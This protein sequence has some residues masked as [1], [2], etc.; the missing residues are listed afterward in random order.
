[1][2]DESGKELQRELQ[3]AREA[4]ATH[5][6]RLRILH[7]I[8][9]AV[10]TEKAP[11]AIA[12]AVVQPLRA[13]LRVPR[14]IVNIFDLAAG[15]AEWLAA[16]GRHRT[17]VGPGVRY[18][19]RLMGDVE[20]LRR[21]EPQIIDVDALPASP[22]RQA[23][24]A[25]GVRIYMAVP[26]IA[27]GELSGAV[28]FGGES[29]HFPVEQMSIAT[30]VATQLAIAIVQARLYERVKQQAAELERRVQERTQDL[31]SANR[32]L[33]AFTYTVSHDLKAP[34]RAIEGF[35]RVLVED[36]AEV[37]DET[38]RRHL[39]RIQTA[40]TRMDRLIE[41]LL[42]YSRIERGAI[43]R[44][45]VP[46]EPIIDALCEE[47]AEE[48]ETRG[49]TVRRD[50]DV[51]QVLAEREGLREAIAN[52]L[53]NAVKFSRNQG[54]PITVSSRRDGD[55]IIITV[56]DHGIGFEMKYHDRIFGMFER[57]H[58]Q[59]AYPGTGVGL[60]IVRKVAERH[61]GRAWAESTLGQ[62]SSFHFALPVALGSGRS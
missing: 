54:E 5:A 7:E 16:A 1:M 13:L 35:A 24:L 31:E 56:A 10:V 18:S 52:L 37:L 14:A 46:L 57:L 23:L 3:S 36:Y 32:E 55:S 15:E 62:G 51:P 49:L 30:E 12:E 27:G 61:G 8:D 25:S 59:E 6:E 44:R 22:E 20:A 41:D 21:G 17:H 47:L 40:A 60:A 28:S 45:P 48:I 53:S 39:A 34:L 19:L 11:A 58:S 4:L 33:E 9:Q 43:E 29:P 26:M 42:R 2:S 50:L 38:G